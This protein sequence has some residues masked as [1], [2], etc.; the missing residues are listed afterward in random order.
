MGSYNPNPGPEINPEQKQQQIIRQEMNTEAKP[1]ISMLINSILYYIE[2]VFILRS[3]DNYRL[4]ALQHSR[5]LYDKYYPT[6]RG[7]KIAFGKLFKDKAW[8]EEIKAEWSHF[9]DPDKR[10]LGK[11]CK[12][13]EW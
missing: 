1:V 5:V 13:L 7:S 4:V 2:C 12:H 8:K 3:K 10:W 6:L 9:Y 11:K